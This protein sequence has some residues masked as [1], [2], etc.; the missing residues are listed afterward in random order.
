MFNVAHMSFG[1]NPGAKLT[2]RILEDERIW[3][4]VEWGLGHQGSGFKGK[5]GP[6]KSH[7]DH[8]CINA[9]VSFDDIEILLDGI[10]VHQDL[11]ELEKK[12]K[13]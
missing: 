2:G 1:C 10:F 6:A 13:R 8:I 9:S 11:R 3:N 12:L 7:T 5:A 4:C